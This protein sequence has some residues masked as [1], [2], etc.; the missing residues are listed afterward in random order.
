MQSKKPKKQRKKLYTM[1]LHKKK[2]MVSA[3]LSK[4]LRKSLGKRAVPVRKNDKVKVVRGKQK[5]KSGKIV[6]VDKKKGRVFI[7]KIGRKKSNGTEILIPIHASNIIVLELETKDEKRFKR[8]KTIKKAGKKEEEK[9]GENK[10]EKEKSKK[11]EIDGKKGR[12]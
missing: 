12:K 7:E 10:T 6:R 4:E 3:H 1:A 11:G 2:K 5:G 8:I 9:K